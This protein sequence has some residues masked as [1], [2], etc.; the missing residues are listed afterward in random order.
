M[1]LNLSFAIAPL[2]L[3]AACAT[4]MPEEPA[5]LVGTSWQFV[6]FTGGDGT[7]LTPDEKAKYTL[8]FGADGRFTVRFDCNR[9]F[10][11][12]K[13]AGKNQ[14]E[15]GAM[16]L[17]RA[18]CPAGSLHDHFV[19]HWPH[20]RSYVLKSGR[21]YLSLMADGG[22]YEFEPLSKPQRAKDVA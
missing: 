20:V 13:T 10:G 11:G 5:S 12:W 3:A 9:G 6:K 18:M 19:K 16:G 14:V 2:A 17:T 8:A 21:L 22:V 1:R 15:F 4:P 7:V